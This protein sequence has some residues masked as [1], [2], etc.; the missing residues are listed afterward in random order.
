MYMMRIKKLVL[1]SS[2]L[3]LLTGCKKGAK[4]ELPEVNLGELTLEEIETG[5]RKE[6]MCESAA[7]PDNWANWKDSWAA[8]KENYGI[9]H[10]DTDMTSAEEIALFEA[11]KDS[12]TK[13]MGDIGFAFAKSAA[14]QGILKAYKPSTW[15]S[16]PDWAKDPEGRWVVSYTGSTAFTV[17]LKATGGKAP[18]SWKELMEGD[19]IVTA[20][21]V[22]GGASAQAAVIACAIANGGS[23]EDVT[24]GVMYFQELAKQGRLDPGEGTQDRLAVGEIEVLVSKFDFSGLEF[25]KSI[26]ASGGEIEVVIPE[27][28]AV[29]TGYC[30]C[31]NQY[32]PHPHAAALAV[33]YML[34]DEGQIDRARGFARPIRSDVVLPDDVKA[35]LL[36]DSDYENVVILQDAEQLEAACQQA[37]L[38]WEEE[39]LP[40]IQ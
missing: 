32:A 19:Y 5:A 31:I 26:E 2:V 11:E 8:L 27:D 38:L 40:Y 17:N 14:E 28:G 25:E 1:L 13:D 4:E 29:Q 20:G 35:G 39:V 21:N 36:P 12:P 10:S 23:L 22:A 7:M 34:S 33:E 16:I 18:K 37:A 9:E 15:E 24:P 30:L 6:G 3:L